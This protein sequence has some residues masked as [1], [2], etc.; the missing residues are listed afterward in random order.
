[1]PVKTLQD[2]FI[3]NLSDIYN[4]E[5]QLGKILP[6]LIKSA[7]HPGLS[8]LFKVQLEDNQ[9]TM[10]QLD[11]VVE[12]SG[13]KLKR[14]KCAAMEGLIGEAKETLDESDKSPVRDAALV[15]NA[16]KIVHYEIAGIGTLAAFAN[17]CGFTEAA[18]TLREVLQDKK[19]GDENFTRFAEENVNQ[20]AEQLEEKQTE[21]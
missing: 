20:D 1:M 2:L 18:D 14:I 12:S 11:R 3:H 6:K 19:E 21:E 15:G 17:H 13:I 9:A 16:Q 10:E 7:E 5:K 8:E 4:A